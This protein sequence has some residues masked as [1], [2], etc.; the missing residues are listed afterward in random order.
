MINGIEITE[1]AGALEDGQEVYFFSTGSETGVYAFKDQVD[2]GEI[3][4]E[5]IY[6]DLAKTAIIN[7]DV[8]LEQH[9]D[10]EKVSVSI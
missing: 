5:D 6:A 1:Q 2:S 9:K 7:R 8:E 3:K 10:S 4:R